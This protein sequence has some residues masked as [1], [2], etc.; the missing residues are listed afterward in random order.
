MT[1]PRVLSIDDYFMVTDESCK[2]GGMVYEYEEE[3][4]TVYLAALAKAMSKVVAEGSDRLVI[5]DACNSQVQHFQQFI[6]VAQKSLMKVNVFAQQ[7][8]DGI[9]KFLR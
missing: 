6:D 3:M 8:G 4:E 1:A 9:Q 7:R 2:K 5:I